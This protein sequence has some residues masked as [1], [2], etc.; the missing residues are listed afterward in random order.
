MITLVTDSSCDLPSELI[1]KHHIKVVPLKVSIDGIEYTEGVNLTGEEFAQKMLASPSLPKTSQPSPGDFAKVFNEIRSEGKEVLCLTISSKLSGT[2]QSACLAKEMA[3]SEGITVFDTLAGSLGHGLQIIRAA[4]MVE[5]GDGLKNILDELII[6]REKMNILILLNTLENIVKGGRLS[7][8][9]GTVASV[10]NIK[11]L[12]EGIE[13][14]V[15]ELGKS[16]GRKKFLRQVLSVIG[17]RREDF[18]N[19]VFGLTYIRNEEEAQALK[20]QIIEKYQPKDVIVN[21]MGATMGTYAGDGG[22]I[23]SF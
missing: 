19:T 20:Q 17:E 8:F 1:K 15:V 5:Q 11:V 7:K 10:L 21:T 2:Y 18:S 4:E 22:M 9:K 6:Y 12:L 13:G 14:E 16:R 3:G 23:L